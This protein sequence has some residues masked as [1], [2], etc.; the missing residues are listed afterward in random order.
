[1][2]EKVQGDNRY[3]IL[4]LSLTFFLLAVCIQEKAEAQALTKTVV[5]MGG[6]EVTV[7]K[8]VNRIV[9]TCYGGATH[10]IAALGGAEKIVGQPS[11]LRFPTLVRMYPGFK[12]T[13]DPG[14]FN[15]VNIEEILNL[16]P[17]VVIASLT[18]EQ[19]NRKI[20]EAGIPVIRVYTGRANDPS[21]SKREFLMIGE[22]LNSKR[23]AEELV[24]FWDRQLQIIEERTADIPQG[25]RKRVYYLLG[26]LTHTN[27]S[28]WWGETLITSAGGINVAHEIGKLRDIT[29]EQLLGWNPDVMILSSNEGKFVPVEEV[30][31]NGQLQGVRAVTDGAVYLC[32]VGTFWWDRPAPEAILGITWLAQTLYPERLGDIDLEKLSQDFYHRFYG[33]RL[34]HDEFASFITPQD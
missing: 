8:N 29:V 3:K 22:L 14:S 32:P 17:D 23:Q 24:E 6:N 4:I 30:M 20:V 15:N 21:D 9:I 18:A 27:G 13:V 19:G 25:M 26:S 7:P 2:K 16:K 12:K 1:M 10:E 5:D 34:S 28:A 11:M 33:Y 31:N